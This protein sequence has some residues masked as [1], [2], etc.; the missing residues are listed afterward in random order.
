M[1]CALKY[2][3][4]F[5]HLHL[6]FKWS[7]RFCCFFFY[8][9]VVMVVG[10]RC[11][12]MLLLLWSTNVFLFSSIL[13]IIDWN[14]FIL[15]TLGK[16]CVLHMVLLRCT[17]TNINRIAP[18]THS[19]ECDGFLLYFFFISLCYCCAVEMHEHVWSFVIILRKYRK[20]KKKTNQT[21][22]PIYLIY[23][24]AYVEE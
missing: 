16:F 9:F 10:P 5:H 17:H 2:C 7:T 6:L 24:K 8:F 14:T 4:L 11:E 23:K 12:L 18:K 20:D 1:L 21:I 3:W 13:I 19:I 22:V 15:V